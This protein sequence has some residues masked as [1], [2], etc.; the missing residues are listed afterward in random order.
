MTKL[1]A[2]NK[3][4]TLSLTG[5]PGGISRRSLVHDTHPQPT[6]TL[7]PGFAFVSGTP[8]FDA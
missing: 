7:I 1:D 5:S 3:I 6:N 4:R 8:V 2:A